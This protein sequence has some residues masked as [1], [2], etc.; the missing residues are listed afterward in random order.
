MRTSIVCLIILYFPGNLIAQDL[1]RAPMDSSLSSIRAFVQINGSIATS[2]Q[3]GLQHI[4]TIKSA[5]YDLVV[6]LAPARKQ[7]NGEEA[8]AAVEAGLAYVQIPVDFKKPAL[9]DLEFFF[10]VMDANS[11]RNVFVHCFAN[12]RVSSFIY[13]YR[14]LRLGHSREEAQ[15]SLSQVWEP[16]EDWRLFIDGALLSN[17]R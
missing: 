2:G 5:G 8:Y 9:R 11:D 16:N 1:S 6:N 17:G 14:V 7:M 4:P 12:M 13:L 3:I 15:L 10:A